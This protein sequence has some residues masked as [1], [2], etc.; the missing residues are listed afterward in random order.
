MYEYKAKVN[1]VVDGDTVIVDIDLGFDVWLNNQYVRLAG[2]D[3]PEL[4]SKD[5]GHRAAGLLAKEKLTNLLKDSEYVALKSENFEREEDKYG[6]ILG[7]IWLP[8]G[9][10]VNNFLLNNHY[11]VSY[12]GENKAET[13]KAHAANIELLISK[14]EIKL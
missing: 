9:T 1:R 13:M 11:G 2:V 10:N 3:T 5:K 12:K 8:S 4:K 7:V 6:R 14:G